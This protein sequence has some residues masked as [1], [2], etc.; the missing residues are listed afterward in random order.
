M[1][2]VHVYKV[3]FFDNALSW[4]HDVIQKGKNP[5]VIWTLKLHYILNYW[6]DLDFFHPQ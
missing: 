4:H 2:K 6:Y 3:V 1:Y 5:A